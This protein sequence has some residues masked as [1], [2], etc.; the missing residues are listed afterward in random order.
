MA[1]SVSPKI[2]SSASVTGNCLGQVRPVQY[3][4]NR[5]MTTSAA[6][7]LQRLTGFG[8][9]TAASGKLSVAPSGGTP[10]VASGT[11]AA[12]DFAK[13]LG[14]ASQGQTV[15]N[16]PVSV[17]PRSGVELTGEQL[18]RLGPA[19][20]KAAAAGLQTAL[21]TIDGK[22]LL[23]DVQSR[24]VTA[25]A[26]PTE[27]AITG[28]DGVVAVPDESD[29]EN[30]AEPSVLPMPRSGYD[31]ASVLSVLAAASHQPPVTS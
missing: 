20:D 10:G 25:A 16:L 23:M 11:D 18:A 19:A 13:L 14:K 24:Q 31:N 17:S 7:L 5:T 21:V 6:H 3:E 28:I 22:S 1:E 9:G 8:A 29:A 15:S 4:S 30:G 12:A 26:Q 2:E 27:R